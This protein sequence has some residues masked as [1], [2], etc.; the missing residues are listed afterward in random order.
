VIVCQHH[1]EDLVVV[2]KQAVVADQ[3]T[4]AAVVEVE[5]EEVV[6]AV[7]VLALAP[8]QIQIL[9]HPTVTKPALIGSK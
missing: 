7:L 1:Q 2:E 4:V 9:G 6:A 8:A 5:A 3:A